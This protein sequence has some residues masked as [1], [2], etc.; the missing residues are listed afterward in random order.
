MNEHVEALEREL[1]HLSELLHKYGHSGQATVVDQILATLKTPAP[2]GSTCG[3]GRAQFGRYVSLPPEKVTKT[4]GP[5]FKQSSNS[6][7]RWTA[8][9]SEQSGPDLSQGL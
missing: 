7:R 3:E 6:L 8:L 2:W 1:S 4:R 9:K 5:S